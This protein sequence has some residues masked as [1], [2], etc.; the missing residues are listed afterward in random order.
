MFSITLLLGLVLIIAVVGA[1][2]AV[3]MLNRTQ[4]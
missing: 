4:R 2:V 1:M 3:Y